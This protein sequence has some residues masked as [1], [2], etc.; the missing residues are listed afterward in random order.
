MFKEKISKDI[1]PKV[2][3]VERNWGLH[4]LIV[5]KSKCVI[6]YM[7]FLISKCN[8]HKCKMLKKDDN[9]VFYE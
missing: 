9:Y 2:K 3:L 5:E 1:F 4:V 8:R 6:P 7:F